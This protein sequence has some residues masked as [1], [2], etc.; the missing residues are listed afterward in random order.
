MNKILGIVLMLFSFAAYADYSHLTKINIENVTPASMRFTFTLSQS[1]RL[2]IFSLNHPNRLVLDF[3][4]TVLINKLQNPNFN[5]SMVN[6]IRYGHP[7]LG[8]LRIVLDASQPLRTHSSLV[9]SG[10][11]VQLVVDCFGTVKTSS[12]PLVMSAPIKSQSHTWTVVIDA[13]HGGKDPGALGKYGAKEKEVV[14]A[15]AERL[16]NL[17]N[18]Q[19]D[20]HAVLTRKGDY[21]VTLRD[22]LRLARRGKADLFM[23]IHAD[24]YFANNASGVSIYALS[25]GGASSEAARWIANRENNSELGGV[26]LEGLADQSYLLRSVLIDLAQTATIT[27]SLRFGNVI[28][29]NLAKNS[30]KLHYPRVEQ[31]PFMVLKS[32]DIPSILIETGF[33]SNPQEENRLHNKKH[34]D[35]IAQGIFQGLR[36]YIKK[37][38]V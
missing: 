10:Q 36:Q 25:H 31:A 14:Y 3:S 19:P 7:D 18:Q 17:I 2:H 27:D 37:T 20:M 34:Q 11:S 21:F 30:I 38:G 5:N 28:L 16:A 26:N 23:S 33:I 29:E 8:V 13:G 4:N 35:E 12:P 24:S 32:P 1:T 6:N 9:R 15:I 22:R